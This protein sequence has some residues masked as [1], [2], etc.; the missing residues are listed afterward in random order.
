MLRLG[1]TSFFFNPSL[2]LSG[3]NI[4]WGRTGRVDW[5]RS[6]MRS[7]NKPNQNWDS[8]QTRRKHRQ[9][10]CNQSTFGSIYWE[11]TQTNEHKVGERRRFPSS[12]RSFLHVSSSLLHFKSIYIP[13][14]LY[15]TRT[16]TSSPLFVCVF[17]C[18]FFW[19]CRIT[20]AA[21]ISVPV[22]DFIPVVS[23]FLTSL[24]HIAP[25]TGRK[26]QS[27]NAQSDSRYITQ[28][29]GDFWPYILHTDAG[30]S[31][32]KKEKNRGCNCGRL[33]Y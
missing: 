20:A 11:A 9:R 25:E 26:G 5:Q 33:C 10:R 13:T 8:F 16:P 31:T 32:R 22:T 4:W 1:F 18:V 19:R 14:T 12:S 21:S 3:M 15:Y 6:Q 27:V 30:F 28:I 17:V 2:S 24:G 23:I 29:Y 7:V